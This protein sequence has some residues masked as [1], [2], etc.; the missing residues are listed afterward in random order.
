MNYKCASHLSVPRRL[1]PKIQ[2]S[3]AKPRSIA[4]KRRKKISILMWNL[5][6]KIFAKNM[7]HSMQST[8]HR[9]R[10]PLIMIM[11]KRHKSNKVHPGLMLSIEMKQEKAKRDSSHISNTHPKALSVSGSS[12]IFN[13]IFIQVGAIFSSWACTYPVHHLP[14]A[15]RE[16][17][18]Y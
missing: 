1:K 6:H 12:F 14:K 9:I 2:V 5:Y 15:N 17:I 8:R 13:E 7:L 3:Q 18:I 10:I 16:T 4:Q 11:M